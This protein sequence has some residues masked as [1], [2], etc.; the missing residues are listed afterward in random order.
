MSG[1]LIN[2]KDAK[3]LW[4]G[5]TEVKKLWVS[6]AEWVKPH[7]YDLMILDDAP[8]AYW[9]CSDAS[10]TA[11]KELVNGWDGIYHA[12]VLQANTATPDGLMVANFVGSGNIRVPNTDNRLQPTDKFTL[13]LWFRSDGYTDYSTVWGFGPNNWDTRLNPPGNAYT[14]HWYNT[15]S[16]WDGSF[17]SYTPGTSPINGEWQHFVI[18]RDSSG[19]FYMYINGQLDKS[20]VLSRTGSPRS[21]A[22]S[23]NMGIGGVATGSRP[24][25]GPVCRVATYDYTLSG[26]N[27]LAHY[28]KGT[29]I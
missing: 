11:A 2:L 26:T 27:V 19:P 9:P 5:Q 25:T 28:Q 29:G 15:Q 10:G 7:E 6:G 24:W 1:P 4:V 14:L 23:S 13:E 20:G 16:N 18:C 17:M 22:G 3:R 12:N 8:T 21:Q